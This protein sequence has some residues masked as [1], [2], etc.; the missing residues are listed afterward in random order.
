MGSF[1]MRYMSLRKAPNK[2]FERIV[3]L[4]V[5][6]AYPI[7]HYVGRKSIAIICILTIVT[8]VAFTSNFVSITNLVRA[9]TVKGI[10]VGIYWDQAC[11]NKTVLLNW[12]S[13]DAGA[14][15]NLTVYVRNEVDS[16]VS[17][18]LGTSK[19]I[20]SASSDYISLNWNYSGQV[21]SVDQVIPLKL[22]LAVS[23]NISEITDFS[24]N[25]IIT[26][27]EG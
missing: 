7:S 8:L 17:L 25:T 4:R 6:L 16:A 20:P 21:L 24:F 18:L 5:R 14:T 11:T 26:I 3:G 19:W 10:G 22:I 27:T 15:N 1:E 23:P 2:I 13:T 12:E 9:D